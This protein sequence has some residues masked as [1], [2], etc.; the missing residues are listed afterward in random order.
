M[1]TPQASW[2]HIYKAASERLQQCLSLSDTLE[3]NEQLAERA[4]EVSYVLVT[5][6]YMHTFWLA[7]STNV[8]LPQNCTK[9][10][11]CPFV[12][13]ITATS[14]SHSVLCTFAI[15]SAD[16]NIIEGIQSSPIF[17]KNFYICIYI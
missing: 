11:S 5:H 12:W 8:T 15:H 16:C 7:V 17:L 13:H 4:A 9:M 2:H 10:M 1:H 6:M 3:S 14:S